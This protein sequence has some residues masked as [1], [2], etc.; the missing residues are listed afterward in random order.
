MIYIHMAASKH[1]DPKFYQYQQS[2]SL[3]K[4]VA[5]LSVASNVDR[6]RLGS[7]EEL[8]CVQRA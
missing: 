5:K 6:A 4:K 7:S 8:G 3:Q 1:A 2:R